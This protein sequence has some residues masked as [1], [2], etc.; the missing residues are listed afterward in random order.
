MSPE[1]KAEYCKAVAVGGMSSEQIEAVGA[2]A[3]SLGTVTGI[4]VEVPVTVAAVAKLPQDGCPDGAILVRYSS[5]KEAMEAVWQLHRC[6]FKSGG[7]SVTLW[8]RQVSGEGASVRSHLQSPS[9]QSSDGVSF[10]FPVVH[11]KACFSF[12]S[13]FYIVLGFCLDQPCFM[14]K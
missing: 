12:Y 8:A 14:S 6:K 2:K 11:R 4:D 5:V 1:Q 10:C 9:T 13:H 3:K 7:K